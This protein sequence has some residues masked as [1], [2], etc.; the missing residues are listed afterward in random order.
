VPAALDQLKVA[1]GNRRHRGVHAGQPR[2]YIA[3]MNL[4]LS[5][6]ETAA[7]IQH[8]KRAIDSDR[9]PLSPRLAPLKAIFAKL[10]PEPAPKP[11][12]PPKV[13]AP[14]SRGRFDDERDQR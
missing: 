12:P 4:D 9:F 14:P 1:E 5:D 8:L 6:A 3:E 13:Y 11:M 7:L 10:R 2:A